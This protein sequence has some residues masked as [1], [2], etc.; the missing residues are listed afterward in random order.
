[1]EIEAY[2]DEAYP[3]LFSSSAPQAKYLV[4]GSLWLKSEDREKFK[5]S[6]HALR[7]KHKIGGEFKWQ[8]SSP[9][10]LLFYQD[11]ISFFFDQD[12]A[13]RFRCIAVD[14]SLVNLAIY[15]NNDQELGFYKF[16]YQMLHK[17]IHDNNSYRIFCD[18][19]SNR[20]RDRLQTLKYY[21]E[22]SNILARIESVQAIRSRESVLIQMADFLTGAAAAK[23]NNRIIPGSAKHK[24]VSHIETCLSTEIVPTALGEKKFNVFKIS[25]QGSW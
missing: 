21:L 16:Y 18:F 8:K 9:S 7:D 11:L 1:M 13:F 17:W 19:K 25:L 22:Y 4:I 24:L 12:D 2:C 5:S 6:I 3:D 23:I 20:R 15:H 10:R 14:N